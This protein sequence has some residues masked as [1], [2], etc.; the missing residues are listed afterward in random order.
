M[1][2]IEDGK[3]KN[4]DMSVS[5]TQRGNVSAKTAPR[6]F[7]SARDDGLAY[8][9]IYEG[10][11][12][13]A[14]DYV[15]YLKNTSTTRNMFIGDLTAGGVGD[16]KWKL[17]FVI[18][19]AAAGESVTAT[20]MNNSKNI[21]AEATVMAGNTSITGLTTDGQVSNFRSA[22]LSSW[23]EAFDGSLVLGPGDAIALETDA[24]T[25]GVVEMDI[26]FHY[27]TIG[28]T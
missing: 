10:I 21:P 27:E 12:A 8:S 4:G 11:T 15:A 26:H 23:E 14:G 3:G 9:A 6:N 18:G 25:I 28:A 2:K 20:P 22:A 5:A 19:T 13:V 17:W 1:A 7:Y 16:V 24:G